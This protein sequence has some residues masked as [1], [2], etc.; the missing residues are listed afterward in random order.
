MNANAIVGDARVLQVRNLKTALAR[1]NE[2][3]LAAEG[4]RDF[5]RAHL[6]V[7]LA[8]M[9]D[10]D[11]P[12]ASDLRIVDGWNAVLRL[13]NVAKL[14]ADEISALKAAYLARYGAAP[15]K[16]G[17]PAPEPLPTETWIVFDGPQENSYR[18]GACRVTYTGG[19]GPQRAD[20]L[21][22]DYVHAAKLCGCD[23]SRIV[24]ETADKALAKRLA[25]L[26]ARVQPPPA[27]APEGQPT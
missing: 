23:V 11:R 24:V 27:P 26:G 14:S 17:E 18:V 7:A 22:L 12:G 21:I 6:D 9:R 3:L 10:F 1:A 19:E 13:R 20:R 16:E 8:V 5:L 2:R 25:A 15:C 4:E